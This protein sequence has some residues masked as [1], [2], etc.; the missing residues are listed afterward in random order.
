MDVIVLTQDLD[1]EDIKDL[2]VSAPEFHLVPSKNP[3]NTYRV[4]WFSLLTTT[5]NDSTTRC[6]VDILTPGLLGI[7]P[8]PRQHR[9]FISDVPL[10]PLLPLIFLKLRGWTDHLASHHRRMQEKT[11][12]DEEDIDEMLCLGVETYAARLEAEEAKGWMPE[13][14]VEE[15]RMRAERYARAFPDSIGWWRRL[16]VEVNAWGGD[17]DERYDEDDWDD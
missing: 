12:V 9:V 7:P 14:F 4:L 1:P 13:W 17:M 6:K 10:I 8:I 5:T 16:G 2:L 15:G 3:N 11:W